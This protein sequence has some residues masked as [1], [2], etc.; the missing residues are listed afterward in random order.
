MTLKSQRAS[1]SSRPLLA[2]VAESRET[3]G[4]IFHVGCLRADSGVMLCIC[5][6]EKVLKG[7][8]DAVN[9]SLCMA[10]ES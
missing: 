10:L 8:P 4:P 6:R 1:M 9:I 5:S 2:S 3:F 7:P